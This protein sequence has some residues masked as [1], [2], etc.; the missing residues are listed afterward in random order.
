[1]PSKD[2]SHTFSSA[3]WLSVLRLLKLKALHLAFGP[4]MRPVCPN[5]T[6]SQVQMREQRPASR[7]GSCMC[8]V[9]DSHSRRF[10]LSLLWQT[11]LRCCKPQVF[12]ITT[13]CLLAIGRSMCELTA[14]Q[15]A[16]TGTLVRLC[17]AVNTGHMFNRYVSYGD[18]L[19]R[20]T[21]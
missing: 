6:F 5:H 11:G 17:S 4:C 2:I 9:E 19:W 15:R 14:G 12:G 1:M 8:R 13:R 7:H 10:L 20:W 16:S 3:S 18:V 21:V